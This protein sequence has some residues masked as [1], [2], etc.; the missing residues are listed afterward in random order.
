MVLSIAIEAAPWVEAVP[1][2]EQLA[3]TTIEATLKRARS[4]EGELKDYALEISLLLTGDAA[5]QKLN[6][7]YRGQDKPTNVLSFAALEVDTPLPPIGEPIV[8]GDIVVA[9]ETTQKE[10]VEQSKAFPNHL[11]HLIVHGVLHLLGLDHIENNEAE[12]MEQLETEILKGL[13]IPNPYGQEP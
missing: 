12:E 10:A 3:T 5:V 7:D 1:E 8:L 9:F 6:R 4:P 13:G 11:A 2:I